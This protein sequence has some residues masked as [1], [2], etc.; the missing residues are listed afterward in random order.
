MI[1]LKNYAA[2]TNIV[3]V[4][5]ISINEIIGIH[6]LLK[7]YSCYNVHNRKDM[8]TFNILIFIQV[9]IDTK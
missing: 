7:N 5:N 3:T 4:I 1:R 8:N 2:T 9:R 6:D